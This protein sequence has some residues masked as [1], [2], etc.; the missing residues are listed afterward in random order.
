MWLISASEDPA[1][2][3]SVSEVELPD[4][5]G[6]EVWVIC[7]WGCKSQ[8]PCSVNVGKVAEL[9]GC[10]GLRRSE[11]LGMR[12]R[13]EEVVKRFSGG[14][15]TGGGCSSKLEDERTGVAGMASES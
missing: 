1:S 13:S 12:G 4:T 10:A 9:R 15:L 8:F 3:E 5:A 14:L 6:L 7:V 2:L 11:E